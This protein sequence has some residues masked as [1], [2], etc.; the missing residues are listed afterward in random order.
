MKKKILILSIAFISLFS[1]SFVGD[2]FFEI[3]KNLDIFGTLYKELNYY[4]V[5]DVDPA[6]LMRE[7]IDAMLKSLDPYTNFISE[8]E[9][10]DYRFQTTGKYGGIGAL[11]RQK[12][13]Y[14]IIA[15]PYKDYPA[16]KNDLR[17][18]DVIL[19]IDGESAK[20]KNTS[21]VSK[22]LKGQPGTE[23]KLLI[24]RQWNGKKEFLKTL[25][26]EEIKVSS[27]PFAGMLN[28]EVG[29]IRL[30]NFTEKVGKDVR[31]AFNSLKINHP[32]MKSIV[33]DLRGNPGGLL[34]E[35]INVSNVFVSKGQEIVSTK[36]KINEWD[37]LYKTLEEPVD[38]QMPLAVLV[39][40]GS[41]SASEIVSGAIQDLDRG[42]VVGQ[43]TYG[44]GLVQTTRVLSYNTQ[45]KVTTAKYYVPSGRCI[46]AI[47]YS[48]RNDDGSVGKIPDSLKTAF[49]TKTGR[50]VYD[51][52]GIEPDTTI[53]MEEYPNLIISL[54]TEDL[55]FE[56]ANEYRNKHDSIVTPDK[57]ELTDKDF[58]DFVAFLST[59]EYDYK[60]KTEEELEHLEQS[61]KREK[62]YDVISNDLKNMRE[63]ILKDK[64]KNDLY[65]FK[66]DIEEILLLEIVS[67]YYYQEGRLQASLKKDEDVNTAISILKNEDLYRSILNP[68]VLNTGK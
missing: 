38:A 7:G 62:Y 16:Q 12:G 15:E 66:E 37:K 33:F 6:K 58:D 46:Q 29:Y 28:E 14:V 39:D 17:P 3:S 54:L 60:T 63:K 45:L 2:E 35:A 34:N 26:R 1:F 53:E 52:G 67:R 21:E 31:E 42:V 18:G 23:V 59:K 4:Y 5:D 49:K 55:F 30:T 32:E 44:K 65:K 64:K 20:G 22:V 47:D 51:G 24:R 61:V 48:H 41:A 40:R 8:S 25:Q 10:E 56:Y 19:E 43:K 50:I 57:F 68:V 36:G 9:I 11:I 13:D 27:V